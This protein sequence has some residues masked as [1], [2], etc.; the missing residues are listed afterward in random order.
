MHPGTIVELAG[1]ATLG[2][3]AVIVWRD[4]V[5]N[6]VVVILV[7]GIL[8]ISAPKTLKVLLEFRKGQ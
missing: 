5:P 3:V 7:M 6:E 2:L 8:A 1:L 4:G